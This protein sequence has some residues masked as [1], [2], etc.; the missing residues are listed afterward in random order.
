MEMKKEELE[1]AGE[2][3]DGDDED[4]VM[5]EGVFN[6]Q[7]L[8]IAEGAEGQGGG[9]DIGAE[10]DDELSVGDDELQA[11]ILLEEEG[12]DAEL[13]QQDGGTVEEG[14]DD[15]SDGGEPDE[16]FSDQATQS[17]A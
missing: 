16:M 13:E 12:L 2:D 10:A 7:T 14:E 4:S 5:A 8:E 17:N 15:G 11:Q 6:G 1:D 9:I 3:A